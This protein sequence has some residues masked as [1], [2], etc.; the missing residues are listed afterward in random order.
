MKLREEEGAAPCLV[1]Y[2]RPDLRGQKE[3]RYRIVEVGDADELR[4]ALAA[5]LGVRVVVTKTRRLFV[6]DG[7]RIHLDRV[8]DLGSFIEF[9]AV[10]DSDDSDSSERFEELLAELRH[11]FGIREGDLITGSYSDLALVSAGT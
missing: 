3:S 9:E 6:L 2:E 4:E 5:L 10:V 11:A 8:D 1:A 7:V